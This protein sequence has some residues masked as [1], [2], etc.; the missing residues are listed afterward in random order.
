MTTRTAGIYAR[1]SLDAE[2]KGLQVER[3]IEDCAAKAAVLGWTVADTYT[4]NDVSATKAKVRPEYQRLLADLESGRIDAVVVYDLDRLTRKPVELEA[5]IDLS[6]RLKVGLANVS[7]DVDLTTSGGRLTARVKGAVARQEAERIGER[8]KRQKEQRLA[9]GRPPG[10]RYRTFGYTR[11]WRVVPSEAEVVREV[12]RRVGSGESLNSVTRDLTERGVLTVSGTE[13]T[14]QATARMVS[15][16]IYAGFLSY[17]GQRAGRA[18]IEPLIPEALLDAAE[19]R[20]KRPGR[21]NARKHLLSGIAVCGSCFAPMTV[22]GDGS[23]A[24]VCNRQAGGC[25]KVRIK[26]SWLDDAIEGWVKTERFYESVQPRDTEPETAAG[27]SLTEQI[28]ATDAQ[29]EKTRQAMTAEAIDFEDGAA[30]L[31]SLRAKR[32]ALVEARQIKPEGRDLGLGRLADWE[33]A[34]VSR[35]AVELRE[36]VSAIVV[37]PTTRHGSTKF[38]PTRFDVRLTSGEVLPGPA[39]VAASMSFAEV[40]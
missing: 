13:W 16:P 12:F 32:K 15:S 39:V 28:E 40:A 9:S 34:D 31:K 30:L 36:R 35:K 33:R 20:Q 37:K 29:I 8:V 22:T 25:G 23:G 11:D 26:R 6:D 38:D 4:D 14:Y 1:I 19:G 24:Y 10:S 17:K 5:F 2:G 21:I 18:D 27:P 7:G 3:Q